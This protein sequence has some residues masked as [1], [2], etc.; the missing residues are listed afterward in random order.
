MCIDSTSL[1][2]R[3]VLQCC[4][5]LQPVLGEQQLDEPGVSTCGV[6]VVCV[7]VCVFVCL[8]VYV[9]ACLCIYMSL[10]LCVSV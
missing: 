5:V 6:C 3:S 8:R 9:S 10:F 4:S 1:V 7:T 2:R